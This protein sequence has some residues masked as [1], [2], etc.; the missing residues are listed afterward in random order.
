MAAMGGGAYTEA[1][2]TGQQIVWG[3]GDMS[4]GAA[5]EVAALVAGGELRPVHLRATRPRDKPA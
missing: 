2:F 4:P 1:D 5:A 3:E